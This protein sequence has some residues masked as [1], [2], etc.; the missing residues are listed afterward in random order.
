MKRFLLLALTIGA[1]VAFASSS[2]TTYFELEKPADGDSNWGS[3]LRNNMDVID[4]QMH[5]NQTPY[6][7]GE[8]VV[9]KTASYT[10]TGAET[11][12]LCDA[13]SGNVTIS[14]PALASSAYRKYHVKKIDVSANTCII[15]GSGSETI[16]GST[17]F[18]ISVQYRSIQ[19][20]NGTSGWF[21]L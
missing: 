1:A 11:V 8:T 17:T 19:V 4:L 9:T 13:T 6:L 5:L 3:A 20:V 18:T 12:I 10:A 14:L 21:I 7:P 2:Y 16:D 15:D